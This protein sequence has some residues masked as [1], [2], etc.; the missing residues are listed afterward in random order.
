MIKQ[1]NRLTEAKAIIIG[2]VIAAVVSLV[3]LYFQFFYE[4]PQNINDYQCER[5][6]KRAE[7]YAN[8]INGKLL[9]INDDRKLINYTFWREKFEEIT[10]YSCKEIDYKFEEIMSAF[11]KASKQLDL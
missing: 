9:R 5:I 4:N 1:E 2:A 7:N 11:E 6:I 3:A 8:D 10:R